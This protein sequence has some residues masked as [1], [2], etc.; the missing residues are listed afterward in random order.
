MRI[1]TLAIL[2]AATPAVAETPYWMINPPP[3]AYDQIARDGRLAR[4]QILRDSAERAAA[5]YR[6]WQDRAAAEREAESARINEPVI[7]TYQVYDPY[8]WGEPWTGR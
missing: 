3:S 6:A 7:R 2:L 1:L 5:D 8:A 4:D